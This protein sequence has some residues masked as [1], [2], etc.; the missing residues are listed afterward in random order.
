MILKMYKTALYVILYFYFADRQTQL[1]TRFL[2]QRNCYKENEKI[3]TTH[4]QTHARTQALKRRHGH[5]HTHT[6]A[7][8]HLRETAERDFLQWTKASRGNLRRQRGVNFVIGEAT[9]VKRISIRQNLLMSLFLAYLSYYF[10]SQSTY[11]LRSISVS[12]QQSCH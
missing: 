7:R 12:F 5:G 1:Q 4:T 3:M 9:G 10:N 2:R 6:H 8:K 11:I